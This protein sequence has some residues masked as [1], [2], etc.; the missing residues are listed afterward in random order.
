MERAWGTVV[1]LALLTGCTG[2]S[3]SDSPVPVDPTLPFYIWD[4]LE[5]T[6][7]TVDGA[8]AKLQTADPGETFAP[9]LDVTFGRA[10]P[11][12][13]PVPWSPEPGPTPER[14]PVDLDLPQLMVWGEGLPVIRTSFADEP[15]WS[16][17][18]GQWFGATDD[19][20]RT[21]AVHWHPGRQFEGWTADDVLA[22]VPPVE[23]SAPVL[24]FDAQSSPTECT[25]LVVQT[26]GPDRASTFRIVL[27]EVPGLQIDLA[28]TTRIFPEYLAAVG[29]DGVFRGF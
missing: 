25:L 10:G 23:E 22:T 20:G 29:T 18:G 8:R 9:T 12:G 3:A 1:A 26:G 28:L 17:C 16:A 11:P 15:G 21:P 24:L 27:S 13:E 4:Q 7:N 14:V 6:G 2:G 5:G 19:L